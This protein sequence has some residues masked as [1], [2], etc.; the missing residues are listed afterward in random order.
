MR[1]LSK[2]ISRYVGVPRAGVGCFESTGWGWGVE[3]AGS[4]RSWSNLNLVVFNLVDCRDR[5]AIVGCNEAVAG[6]HQCRLCHRPAPKLGH[7][8]CCAD[9]GLI[10]RTKCGFRHWVR[11]SGIAN[12]VDIGMDSR[13]KRAAAYRAPTFTLV[14]SSGP[15]NGRCSLR[16][17]NVCHC[18]FVFVELRTNDTSCLLYTSDAADE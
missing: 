6:I 13:F 2:R 10:V 16:R 12:D 7:N 4:A 1:F 9:L 14:K 15:R 17:N 5:N 11:D 8:R 18:W 3:S